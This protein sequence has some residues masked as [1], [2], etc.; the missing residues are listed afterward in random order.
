MTETDFYGNYYRSKYFEE[1]GK[2]GFNALTAYAAGVG[3]IP[4]TPTVEGR[5]PEWVADYCAMNWVGHQQIAN[6]LLAQLIIELRRRP[7]E[8]KL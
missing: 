5:Q 3:P 8:A 2:D 7:F 1:F 4:P 6:Y